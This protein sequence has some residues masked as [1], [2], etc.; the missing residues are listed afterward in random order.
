LLVAEVVVTD[1]LL[2]AAA[3]ARAVCLPMYRPYNQ[4]PLILLCL[5]QVVAEQTVQTQL[6]LDLLLLVVDK[7]ATEL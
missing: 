1:H 6:P 4:E 2:L 3:V 7:E 5:A